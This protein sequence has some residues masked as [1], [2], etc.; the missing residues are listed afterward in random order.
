M[1][2]PVEA[3]RIPLVQPGQRKSNDFHLFLAK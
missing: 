1:Q 2:N 3:A